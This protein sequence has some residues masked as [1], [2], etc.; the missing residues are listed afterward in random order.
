MLIVFPERLHRIHTTYE[1]VAES[2]TSPVAWLAS[3]SART[4]LSGCNKHTKSG[5][6]TDQWSL[7]IQPLEDLSWRVLAL[8]NDQAYERIAADEQN[9]VMDAVLSAPFGEEVLAHPSY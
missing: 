6:V 9:G 8:V 4:G 7:H 5:R 1:S 3:W 2:P